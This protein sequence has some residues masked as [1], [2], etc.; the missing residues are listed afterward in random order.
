MFAST[1]CETVIAATRPPRPATSDRGQVAHAHGLAVLDDD[2]RLADLAD[3]RPESRG[4]YQML[5]AVLRVV[6][7]RRQQVL[8]FE[9]RR[10]VV[11]RH[12]GAGEFRRIDDDLDLARVA[13]LHLHAADA[14]DARQRRPL[15][16]VAVVVQVR[17]RQIAREVQAEDRKGGRREPIDREVQLRGQRAADLGDVILHLLERDDH[18]GR[19]VELSGDLGRAAKAARPHPPDARHFHDRLL[20]RPRDRQHHR[21]RRRRPGVRDRHDARELQRRID[22][23]RQGEAAHDAGHGEEH[24]QQDDGACV[25]RRKAR[26][27]HLTI[28]IAAPFGRES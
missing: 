16:V 4:K 23:A 26:Q 10:D 6:A 2:R 12:A 27:R 13:R 20:D 3:R 15:D 22:A 8:P 9:R 7:H 1:C 11:H 24:R 18:V 17:R 25:M 21:L 14:V 19:R 5:D 28:W